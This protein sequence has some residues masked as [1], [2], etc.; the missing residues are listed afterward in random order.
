MKALITVL[1][2]SFSFSLGAA[3]QKQ[4]KLRSASWKS[5]LTI[6]DK[7]EDDSPVRVPSQNTKKK[8]KEVKP[9][10]WNYKS[11]AQIDIEAANPTN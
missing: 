2:F 1:L 7:V 4:P 3:D 11:P 10:M 9:K 8:E 5:D 6:E